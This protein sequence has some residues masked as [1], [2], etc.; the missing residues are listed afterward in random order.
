MVK[1]TLILQKKMDSNDKQTAKTGKNG[2]K[3]QTATKNGK[4]NLSKMGNIGQ[5][6]AVINH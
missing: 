2:Q 4:K 5:K 6:Q 1:N 3:R